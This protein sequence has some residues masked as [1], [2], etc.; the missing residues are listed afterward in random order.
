[1][2]YILDFDRTL[3]NTDELYTHFQTDGLSMTTFIPEVWDTYTAQDYLYPDVVPF[4]ASKQASDIF[5]LTALGDKYGDKI[6]EYQTAKIEQEPIRSLVQEVVYVVHEKDAA[7]AK[8]A[9]QYA[10]QETIVFVDDL[11]A[12]CV[13]VKKALPHS[14]CF[15]MQRDSTAIPVEL[16]D[17]PITLVHTLK[18]VDDKMNTL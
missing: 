3:F 14:H 13:A 11:L 12:H 6:L 10:P 1:M 9:K 8:I 4:L 16:E 17:L 7:A 15:L 2:K 18:E 5:I